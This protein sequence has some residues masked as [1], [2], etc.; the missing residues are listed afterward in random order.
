M[1]FGPTITGVVRADP[2]LARPDLTIMNIMLTP[3]AQTH[4]YTHEAD[5]YLSSL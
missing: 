1:K 5:N 3:C 2:I 4:W